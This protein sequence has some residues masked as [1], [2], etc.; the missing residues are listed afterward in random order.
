M[1]LCLSL[2]WVT[3]SVW[4]WR[5]GRD[6]DSFLGLCSHLFAAVGCRISVIPLLFLLSRPRD[7]TCGCDLD[8]YL[9]HN[10]QMSSPLG[11][12]RPEESDPVFAMNS[13]G[14]ELNCNR[15]TLAWCRG[16]QYDYGNS[17]PTVS[18]FWATP[19]LTS[20]TSSPG[21]IADNSTGGDESSHCNAA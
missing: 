20:S 2:P 3:S 12:E 14:A 6:L 4:L 15:V 8:I 5:S 7:G 21:S 10:S 11:L 1:S 18:P 19:K 16:C 9:V 13:P 17:R